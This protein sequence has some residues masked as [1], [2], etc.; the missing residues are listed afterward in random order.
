MNTQGDLL[1]AIFI[2]VTIYRMSHFFLL[3]VF[4]IGNKYALERTP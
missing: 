2:G 1:A 4:N 3:G